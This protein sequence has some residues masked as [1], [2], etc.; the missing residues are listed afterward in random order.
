MWQKSPPTPI[1]PEGELTIT[2]F[3]WLRGTRFKS[4]TSRGLYYVKVVTNQNTTFYIND[5]ATLFLE[6]TQTYNTEDWEWQRVILP[7]EEKEQQ[8]RDFISEI[9]DYKDDI[10]PKTANYYIQ[11]YPLA[12][13]YI[14]GYFIGYK[15]GHS[16][17]VDEEKYGYED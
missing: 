3:W 17:G 1:I 13:D 15:Y 8:E 7:T 9:R 12:I 11:K 14:N 10:P 5:G 4:D 16:D 2:E 6:N